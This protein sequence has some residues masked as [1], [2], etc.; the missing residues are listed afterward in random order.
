MV[1]S[2]LPWRLPLAASM[3][4]S[5][6]ASVRCSRVRKSR[7]GRRLGATVRFTVAGVT[8]FRCSFAMIFALRP[9]RLFVQQSFFGQ[10]SPYLARSP[11]VYIEGVRGERAK[12]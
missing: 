6:S 12:R 9:D 5:T 1:A 4:R 8:S 3:R 10:Y 11:K 7:L 2:L